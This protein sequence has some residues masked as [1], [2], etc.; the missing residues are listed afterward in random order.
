MKIPDVEMLQAVLDGID[1]LLTQNV[2]P[3]CRLRVLDLRRVHQ[4]FW[5]VWAG[6]EDGAA[7]TRSEKKV[8]ERIQRKPLRGLKVVIDLRLCYPVNEHQACL[9]HWVQQKKD[10]LRKGSL[11]LCCP[12]MKIY[13]LPG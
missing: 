12:K 2:H 10:S 7:E 13:C 1:I 3:R 5:D 11:W 8:A 4:N 6:R 9:L